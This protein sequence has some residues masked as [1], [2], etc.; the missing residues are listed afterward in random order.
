M[1]DTRKTRTLR[2]VLQE[3]RALRELLSAVAD[4]LESMA[5]E[6]GK[7]DAER[8]RMQRWAQLIRKRLLG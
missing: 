3:N 2:E 5:M 6:A 7:P 8:R 4:D 1:S